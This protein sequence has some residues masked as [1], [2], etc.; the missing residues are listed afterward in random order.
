MM[1][2]YQPVFVSADNGDGTQPDFEIGNAQNA[3]QLGW[4]LHHTPAGYVTEFLAAKLRFR[5]HFRFY[6]Q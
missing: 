3:T 2:P 1:Q 4:L 6:R 5:A